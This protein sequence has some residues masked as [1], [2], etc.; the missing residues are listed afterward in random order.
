MRVKSVIQ[1][2]IKKFQ[3]KFSYILFNVTFS[4]SDLAAKIVRNYKQQELYT[5]YSGISIFYILFLLHYQNNLM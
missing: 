1:N 2:V 4:T 5:N 3:I